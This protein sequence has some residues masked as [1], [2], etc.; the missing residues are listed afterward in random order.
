MGRLFFGE[1]MFS[2]QANASKVAFATLAQFLERAGFVLIDCQMHTSHLESLGA[3]EI[4][5][6]A[7]AQYLARHLD[8]PND[9]EWAG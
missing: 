3:R 7:F 8:E 4:S 1:S 5:R 9:A 2:R 6:I